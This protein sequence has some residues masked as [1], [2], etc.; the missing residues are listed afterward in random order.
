V[1]FLYCDRTMLRAFGYDKQLAGAESHVSVAKLNLDVTGENEEKII[2]VVV[3]MPNKLASY[4]DDHQ[5][6][7]IE[8]ADNAWLPI[9]GEGRKL[10]GKIYGGFHMGSL[11]N[12]FT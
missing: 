8:T 9:V 1:S 10:M 12:R 3:S 4:F 5:I 2:G 11:K 6:V 7:S